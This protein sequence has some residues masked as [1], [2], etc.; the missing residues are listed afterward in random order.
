MAHFGELA[1]GLGYMPDEELEDALKAQAAEAQTGKSPRKIGEISVEKS[2]LEEFEV[3]VILECQELL[4]N[5]EVVCG[6]P[7][8]VPTVQPDS[9]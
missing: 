2:F 1:K 8:E 5:E 9:K 3:K 7:T 6:L 4:R